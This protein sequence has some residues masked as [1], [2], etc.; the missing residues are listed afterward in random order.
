VLEWADGDADE[1]AG[2]TGFSDIFWENSALIDPA[3]IA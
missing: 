2:L 1:D 3:G